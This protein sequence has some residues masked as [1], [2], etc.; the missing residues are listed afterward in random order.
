MPA[1]R[2]L[3]CLLLTV[4]LQPNVFGQA[5]SKNTSTAAS[6]RDY[7]LQ[8]TMLGYFGEDG[9]RNPVLKANPGDR[10]RITI[11]NGETMTHDIALEKLGVKSK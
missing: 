8:A 5:V 2:F 3:I 11:V 4:A 6:D 9:T 10:V 1:S 7:T